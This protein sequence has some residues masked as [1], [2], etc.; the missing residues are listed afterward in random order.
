MNTMSNAAARRRQDRPLIEV[1]RVSKAFGT[2]ADPIPVLEDVSLVVR[3]GEIVA[4]LGKSGG[5]KSTL[6]RCLAGLIEPSAGE[7]RYQGSVLAGPNPG[8][9]MVFQ[10]FALMPW[11]TVRQNVELGLEARLV[12]SAE[13]RVRAERTRLARD[14]VVSRRSSPAT[15]TSRSARGRSRPWPRCGPSC[16]P[17]S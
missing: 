13:R 6:L 7:V 5:G 16:G 3:P 1:R 14:V 15:S 2:S 4:L 8:T 10:S 12:P 17:G 11:L 9:A